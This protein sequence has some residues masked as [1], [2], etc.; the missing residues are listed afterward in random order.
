MGI[1]ER[2]KRQF[3]TRENAIV[4]EAMKFLQLKEPHELTI[5]YLA[6]A[7]EVSRAT[8]YQHFSNKDDIYA[9]ILTRRYNELLQCF[10]SLPEEVTGLE[11]L[12][13]LLK[14][15][16]NFCINN[17]GHYLVQRKCEN[18]IVRENLGSREQ[19]AFNQSR[20]VRLDF[21]SKIIISAQ[22]SGTLKP[23]SPLLLIGA[24]WGML[25]GAL[26]ILALKKFK[27]ELYAPE[28]LEHIEDYILSGIIT[29]GNYE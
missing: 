14:R 27:E 6:Q 4:D 15:Y 24:I 11:Q 3:I 29:G 8:I 22:R 18:S 16:L 10:A 17:T 12:K 26:D 23:G 2:K 20:K 21:F 25:N 19:E 5:D 13:L 28:Y 1:A 7:L 9:R